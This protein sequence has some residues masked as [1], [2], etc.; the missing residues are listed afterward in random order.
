MQNIYRRWIN[1]EYM[2]LIKVKN[3]AKLSCFLRFANFYLSFIYNFDKV[4]VLPHFIVKTIPR[5]VVNQKIDKLN[6]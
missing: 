4:I 6:K 1:Q 2:Y 5:I 3:Y